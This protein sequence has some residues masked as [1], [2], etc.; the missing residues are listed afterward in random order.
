[1]PPPEPPS[2]DPPELEAAL[3]GVRVL[4]LATFIAAPF[5][6]TL[7][8]E[9]GAEVIKIEHP[10]GGD[11]F[12]RFGSMT[13]AG[14]SLAWLSEARNKESVTLN[15]KHPDGQDLLRRLVEGA[16]VLCENFRPGTLERWGLGWQELSAINPGLVMLRITG[17]G[18]TGPYRDRP[19]FARTAHAFGGLTYLAGMPDGPPVTPGSTSLA[20]YISGIYGAFGVMMALRVRERSGSGQVIDL[21]LYESVFR[22]LDELA[23]AYAKFGTVRQ[24][25][26]AGTANACPHGQFRCADGGWVALACTS[27]KMFQRLASAMGR[28]ELAA[29]ETYGEAR[30]RLDGREA[31]E[32]LVGDWTG[33]LTR[34]EVLERCQAEEVPCSA[35]NSIA[36]IFADPQYRDRDNLVTLE[37]RVAGAV[38]VPGVVPRLSATPGR[39]A[40][41]GPRLGEHNAEVYRRLLDLDDKAIARLKADGVI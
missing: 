16:D 39:I 26:G 35:V 33:S 18:Q 7:M 8:A 34:A 32:R 12:R 20:D 21:A 14:D 5:C 2:R 37:D 30:R 40:R 38:T 17:Y 4:D 6:A 27:D 36:D 28:P 3:A 10:E 19:G 24:P 29:P 9:F 31:V 1:M 23:P 25:E 11:P 22:L 15:L 41:L 13:E